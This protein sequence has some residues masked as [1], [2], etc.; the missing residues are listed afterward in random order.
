MSSRRAFG[1]VLSLTE[2]GLAVR[3]VLI[4]GATALFPAGCG[5]TDTRASASGSAAE[6]TDL[7]S[8]RATAAHRPGHR[9]GTHFAAFGPEAFARAAKE[10]KPILLHVAAVWCHWCHV[11]EEE[12]YGDPEVAAFL[13][14][15]FVAIRVDSDARPDVAERYAAFGW[16][17]TALL[18]PDAE[19]VTERR[20][21]REKDEFL[22]L[23]REV[24]A[25]VRAGRKRERSASAPGSSGRVA[26]PTSPGRAELLAAKEFAARQLDG[27][28]DRRLG[29]FGEFQKYP[30]APPVEELFRRARS[31]DDRDALARAEQT[32]DGYARLNDPVFGGLYQYSVP[33]SWDAPHFEKLGLVQAGAITAFAEAAAFSDRDQRLA[34]ADSVRRYVD[35][36]LRRPDGAFAATQDADLGRAGGPPLLGAD[37]YALAAPE[38]LKLGVPRI[39]P[40]AY[41]DVNG[42]LIEAYIA[43][44]SRTGDVG[45]LDGAQ[46]AAATLKRT[47][48]GPDGAF[49]HG[50]DGSDPLRYLVDQAAMGRAFLALYEATGDPDALTTARGVAAFLRSEL[51]DPSG[52]FFAHT[53]DP[54]ARGVFASRRKPLQSNATAARFLLRLAAVVETD[55]AALRRSA[56][57]ALLAFVDRDLLAA[58]GREVADYVLA[59][60]ELLRPG[61]HFVLVSEGPAAEI[62]A[63]RAAALAVHFPGR[64]ISHAVPGTTYQSLGRPALYVCFPDFCSAPLTD[65]ATLPEDIRRLARPQ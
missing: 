51:E 53:V 55:A 11:M 50:T 34:V 49:R 38:R 3:I 45:C 22:S 57:S 44:Y 59:V 41:A 14:S 2:L 46:R 27:L 65:P 5:T 35:R 64:T 10:R 25:D 8:P 28:Y 4:V 30:L 18:T 29:G 31:D 32:L 60:D 26:A 42:A 24:E 23:L 52:G 16:P 20:G 37:Y 39:D 33:R 63:F 54:S 56:E 43:L 15:R 9:P 58:E 40:A 1:P 61:P 47:H 21:Y 48:L 12:T 19:P 6:R 13:D 7:A 62:A 36:F 17:A